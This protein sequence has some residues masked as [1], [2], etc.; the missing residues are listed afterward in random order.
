MITPR[1]ASV[2]GAGIALLI[3]WAALGE[4][5][6]LGAGAALIVAVVAAVAVTNWNRPSIDVRRQLNPSLVHEGDRTAVE[7]SISNLRRVPVFNLTVSDGVG[8]LGTARF[9]VGHLHRHDPAAAS[10]RI[11]CRPRGVYQVG[12]ARIK[13]GDPLGLASSES[14]T[15]DVDELI[16]Y[17]AT[18]SLAG[19]PYVRGRDPSQMAS[20][21]EQSQRGGED[22]FTLRS[23]RSGDDLRRVHWPS[24]AKL[25]EL[26]IRQMENPW[27][28]RA[29][30]F[31]D[32]RQR[33]YA[34]VDTFEKAV[35]GT[36]SVVKHL[37]AGGFAADLWL[38]RELLDV[39]AYTAA[40]EA[41]ALV[42]TVPAVDIKAVASRLRQSG[43][44]GALVLVTGAPDEDLLSVHR[45]LASQHRVTILLAASSA[46]G[47]LIPA[48]QRLGAKTVVTGANPN[49]A[50]AW[51]QTMGR[52]WLSA[53]AG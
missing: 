5:E 12:P 7:L 38:G 11:V 29:L 14:S 19:Y 35:K 46:P 26:M 33:S 4:I 3:S 44:G 53:S 27:Q 49:W 43:R 6:L 28:S 30:V 18:E 40:M 34:D 24:S 23:Y 10:Y 25:D 1:G 16:V 45:H 51:N 42:Q 15:G 50:P 9:A 22:F 52:T 32:V 36:A 21:P 37:V 8:G 20:R 17:P 2:L 39:S 41:L 31:F 13:V 48:F 47:S